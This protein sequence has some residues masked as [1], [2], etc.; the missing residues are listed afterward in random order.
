MASLDDTE[1]PFNALEFP[2]AAIDYSK[3]L[4]TLVYPCLTNFRHNQTDLKDMAVVQLEIKICLN[5]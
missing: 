1:T 5:K 3:H 4:Y 2:I